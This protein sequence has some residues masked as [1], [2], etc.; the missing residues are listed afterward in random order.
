[1]LKTF[2]E[3]LYH[4]PINGLG[5]N[6]VV[7]FD[8]G[9]FEAREEFAIR[10]APR[11]PWGAWGDAIEGPPDGLEHGG[12]ASIS[13]RQNNRPDERKGSLIVRLEP[14]IR[15]PRTGIFMLVNDHYSFEDSKEN[16]SS[17]AVEIMELNWDKSLKYSEFIINSI[18]GNFLEHQS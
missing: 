12:L 7:H 9:S 17:Q 14:S 5:I 11:K 13:M 8:C 18:M 6:F 15:L 3:F 1:M 16:D 4:T 2:G 10:L